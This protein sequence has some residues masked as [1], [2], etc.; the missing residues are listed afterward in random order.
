MKLVVVC[1]ACEGACEGGRQTCSW[2]IM[3]WDAEEMMLHHSGGVE[4]V[5]EKCSMCSSAIRKLWPVVPRVTLT[6]VWLITC[7]G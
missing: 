6:V 1:E 5:K 7:P 2:A 3:C 4:H